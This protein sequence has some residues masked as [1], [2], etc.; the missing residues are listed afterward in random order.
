MIKIIK[1]IITDRKNKQGDEK[2]SKE[3][4]ILIKKVER[5]T[6]FAI[7]QYRDVFEKLAEYD[8]Q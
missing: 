6:D 5:G 1:R 7:R 3:R 4:Q 8:R 2:K